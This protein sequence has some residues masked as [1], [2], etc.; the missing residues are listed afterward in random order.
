MA[1]AVMIRHLGYSKGADTFAFHGES[2]SS[3]SSTAAICLD[4]ASK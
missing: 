4:H 2:H 3:T 1:G